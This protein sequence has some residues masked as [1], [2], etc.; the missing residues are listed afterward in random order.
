MLLRILLPCSTGS[1][2]STHSLQSL[3]HNPA[4]SAR[5]SISKVSSCI[6]TPASKRRTPTLVCNSS[7]ADERSSTLG[8]FSQTST[9][10][11]QEQPAAITAG[12]PPASAA[13]ASSD[14]SLAPAGNEALLARIAKAKAYKQ[15]GELTSSS[16]SSDT[17]GTGASSSPDAITITMTEE[18]KEALRQQYAEQL[19]QQ[20][21]Q[22]VTQSSSY[23]SYL[24]AAQQQQQ[25]QAGSGS[26]ALER[27]QQ[28]DPS[29]GQRPAP[30]RP[31]FY[32]N[33]D[34]PDVQQLLSGAPKKA[35]TGS[36]DEAAEWLKGV[37]AD[38][39]GA[40][41][42]LFILYSLDCIVYRSLKFGVY[43]EPNCAGGSWLAVAELGHIHKTV[44]VLF[45][46]SSVWL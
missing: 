22:I 32:T 13:A 45:T 36:A 41:R 10:V 44:P 40:C 1:S 34:A 7:S 29:P 15:T 12:S 24:Q 33:P 4:S 3:H 43:Q 38:K 9:A 5:R 46:Y 19:R 30:A 42:V 20:Q 39:P 16:S 28:E 14:G 17:A 25:Q 27:L 35:G 31:D 23:S 11:S 2:S 6:S 21:A 37:L 26:S 8:N 18:Q